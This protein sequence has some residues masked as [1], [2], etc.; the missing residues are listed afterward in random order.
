VQS[1]LTA[2]WSHAPAKRPPLDQVF[3]SLFGFTRIDSGRECEADKI[4]HPDYNQ[5]LHLD[6]SLY[7][8][9][10]RLKALA[11]DAKVA[12]IQEK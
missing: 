8:V 12:Q 3:L 5:I 1:L 11:N 9:A 6:S 10:P 7:Q 4:P 2:C